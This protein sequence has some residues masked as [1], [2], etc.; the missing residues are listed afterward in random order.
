[1]NLHKDYVKCLSYAKE[2][3]ILASGGLDKNIFL[4]DVPTGVAIN[5]SGLDIKCK[6]L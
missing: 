1:M 5:P 3:E 6:H 4:W 2:R